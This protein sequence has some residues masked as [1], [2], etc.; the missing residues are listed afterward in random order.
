ME[1]DGF[2][3]LETEVSWT[4]LLWSYHCAVPF[5]HPLCNYPEIIGFQAYVVPEKGA[6]LI[7]SKIILPALKPTQ[8]RSNPIR[9]VIQQNIWTTHYSFQIYRTASESWFENRLRL[10]LPIADFV[11]PIFT[12]GIMTGASRIT[13]WFLVTRFVAVN[14]VQRWI[15]PSYL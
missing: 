8:V 4:I 14:F 13:R 11:T 15:Y 3:P 7:L 10:Q 6:K 9:C 5:W 2:G 12:W 1:D